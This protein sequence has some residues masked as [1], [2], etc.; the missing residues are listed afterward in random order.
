MRLTSS[1]A[2]ISSR[3]R[4]FISSLMYSS[5]SHT[6]Q[7]TAQPC[8]LSVDVDVG[9]IEGTYLDVKELLMAL[10]LL[11]P[12]VQVRVRITA[13][14][15]HTHTSNKSARLTVTPSHA[16]TVIHTHGV[17]VQH[18]STS[19]ADGVM[20]KGESNNKRFP[21]VRSRHHQIRIHTPHDS[22]T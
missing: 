1:L 10:Q 13:L 21:A 8:L 2:R 18:I 4:F 20:G 14:L 5:Y 7:H 3:F 19:K 22:E 15:H 9:L 6:T 17:T 16:F 12:R 11:Q